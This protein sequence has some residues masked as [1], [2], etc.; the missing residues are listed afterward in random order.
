VMQFR[1]SEALTLL[2]F[3]RK[4]TVWGITIG[5]LLANLLN[6]MGVNPLDVVF[7]TLATL[8]AAL[9]TARCKKAWLAAIP[10]V[11]SNGIIIGA[12]LAYTLTPDAFMASFAA[13]GVQIALEEAVVCFLLGIPLASLVKKLGILNKK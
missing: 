12:M 8:L 13:F 4:D 11:V 7:G 10:P 9:V 2:P 5:C 3:I 1:V 6:P